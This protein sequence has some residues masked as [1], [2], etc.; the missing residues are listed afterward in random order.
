MNAPSLHRLSRSF[1][2]SFQSYHD[3]AQQQAQIAS[4]LAQRLAGFVRPRRFGLALELGCGTGHL[5]RALR[6]HFE[7]DR[8]ILNDLTPTAAATAAEQDATFLQGDLRQIHWPGQP[9]LVASASTLQWLE[10][11][12]DSLRRM[13]MSLTQGGWLAVS[14]FGP[15]QYRE[16]AALGHPPQAPG[17]CPPEALA[18]ALEDLPNLAVRDI[19]GTQRQLWFDSPRD[20]LRHLRATGVNG[21]Q[22]RLWTRSDLNR[23]SDR[24]TDLFAEGGQVPLTYHATWVIA[25]KL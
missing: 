7:I 25:Q 20:V 14:G 9:D 24:Y 13:A 16:L 21:G 22:S 19:G 18:T 10:A 4:S 8:L 2:R 15:F 17:L 6:Q 11:P 12:G 23:F 1:E 3:A 5:T